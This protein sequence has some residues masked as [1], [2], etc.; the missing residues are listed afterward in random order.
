MSNEVEDN[1]AYEP[2]DQPDGNRPGDPQNIMAK[3]ISINFAITLLLHILL[4][5]S[6]EWV[7]SAYLLML[8]QVGINLLV[9]LILLFTPSKKIGVGMMISSLVTLVIGLGSCFFAMS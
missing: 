4:L 6:V 1:Y 7:I 9:G 2:L 5:F 8:L 3:T